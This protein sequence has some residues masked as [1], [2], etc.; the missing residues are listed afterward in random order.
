MGVPPFIVG[1]AKLISNAELRA[2]ITTALGAPGK[3]VDTELGADPEPLEDW[4]TDPP[5]QP[6]NSNRKPNAT[7]GSILKSVMARSQ[8][9]YRQSD[10][11]YA[12]LS[13]QWATMTEHILLSPA[14]VQQ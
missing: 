14:W 1:G 2:V 7:L 11:F 6:Y 13:R 8:S 4:P 12:A 9:N 3:P 5:L 10:H